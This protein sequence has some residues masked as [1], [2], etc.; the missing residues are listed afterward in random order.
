MKKIILTASQWLFRR[1]LAFRTVFDISKPE[2]KTVLA[3]LAK[4]C[5]SNP[6]S[7]AGSPIDTHQLCINIGRRQVLNHILAIVNLPD[8]KLNEI[9]QEEQQRIRE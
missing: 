5:P 4:I 9:I 7:G 2:V 8:E 6:A 3:E 1:R